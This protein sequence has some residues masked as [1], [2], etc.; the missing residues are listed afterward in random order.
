VIARRLGSGLIVVDS[1]D[2]SPD[3]PGVVS[4]R[5]AADLMHRPGFLDACR[6]ASKADPE[7]QG[8]ETVFEHLSRSNDSVSRDHEQDQIR[9]K[10]RNVHV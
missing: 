9:L 3:Q 10:R 6:L 4:M 1:M 7:L 8:K 2:V 5:E